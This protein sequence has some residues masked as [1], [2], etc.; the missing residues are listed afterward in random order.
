MKKF[1]LLI[2][3]PFILAII[4]ICGFFIYF[5]IIPEVKNNIIISKV[6]SVVYKELKSNFP[7]I[8]IEMTDKDVLLSGGVGEPNEYNLT[9]IYQYD[10]LI[11]YYSTIYQY[12]DT[13]IIDESKLYCLKSHIKT[14]VSHPEKYDKI[15]GYQYIQKFEIPINET[16]SYFGSISVVIY[17]KTLKE[18]KTQMKNCYREYIKLKNSNCK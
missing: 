15:I 6:N 7:N 16:L 10:T 17:G 4:L 3:E 8:D 18:G 9:P 13:L 12:D 2:C 1:L 11:T 14:I 5:G